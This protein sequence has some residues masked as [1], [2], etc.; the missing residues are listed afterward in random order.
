[1]KHHPDV[2]TIANMKPNFDL[3]KRGWDEN[4]PV[5]EHEE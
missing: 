2:A 5:E 4:L 1:M 3:G